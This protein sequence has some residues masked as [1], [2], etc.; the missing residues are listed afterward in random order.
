MDEF[1]H[2]RLITENILT[3]ASNM[4]STVATEI[5]AESHTSTKSD[6]ESDGQ[7]KLL[8]ELL[9]GQLALSKANADGA[10]NMFKGVTGFLGNIAGMFA[11]IPIIV[12][13]DK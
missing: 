12:G 1:A 2:G 8:K 7:A 13:V 10:A 3:S 4:G 5:L 6:K 9:D 11:L